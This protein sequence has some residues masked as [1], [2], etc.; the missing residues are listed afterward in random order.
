MWF[1][2]SVQ[3]PGGELV[4]A[5]RCFKRV[6]RDAGLALKPEETVSQFSLDGL[7]GAGSHET[8]SG[9]ATSVSGLVWGSEQR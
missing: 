3:A 7:L 9:W 1:E 8:L 5:L 4:K 6:S 2:T